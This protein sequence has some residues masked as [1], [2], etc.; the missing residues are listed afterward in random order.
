MNTQIT[1]VLISQFLL[2]ILVPIIAY[3]FSKSIVYIRKAFERLPSN[4]RKVVWDYTNTVVKSIMQQSNKD[5]TDE[6]KKD[7][8]VQQI[9]FLLK[10][11][12]I[13]VSDELIGHVIEQV[14]FEIKKQ[15]INPPQIRRTSL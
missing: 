6:Q 9:Q 12:N 2:Y 14:I 5:W 8:A 10:K 11:A 4:I 13:T 15:P 1:N 7:Y 3:C